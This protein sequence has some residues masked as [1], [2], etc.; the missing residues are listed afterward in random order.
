MVLKKAGGTVE[1]FTTDKV[2]GSSLT[3]DKIRFTFKSLPDE[4]II[5]SDLWSNDILMEATK[6]C[7]KE[8]EEK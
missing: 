6:I 7:K 4:I 2:S 3:E 5:N 8:G 1:P